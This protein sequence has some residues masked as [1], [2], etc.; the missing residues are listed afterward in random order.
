MM[1]SKDGS[2]NGCPGTYMLENRLASANPADAAGGCAFDYQHDSDFQ[3]WLL[4]AQNHCSE[5]YGA[6]PAMSEAE[7]QS[8]MQLTY[9]TYYG[10][11][12]REFSP[13]KWEFS[14]PI[15]N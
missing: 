4:A 15:I 5:L 12:P 3:N 13:I 1:R 2:P 14:T 11:T 7:R 10:E 6:L 9:N 8:F